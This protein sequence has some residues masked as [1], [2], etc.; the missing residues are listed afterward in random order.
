MQHNCVLTWFL[1]TTDT[2]LTHCNIRKMNQP[3][4]STV[5]RF[6]LNETYWISVFK[7]WPEPGPAD[8]ADNYCTYIIVGF[9]Q[10]KQNNNI[11]CALQESINE[12]FVIM[13]CHHVS[14]VSCNWQC[15]KLSNHLYDNRLRLVLVVNSLHPLQLCWNPPNPK[16]WPK[17]LLEPDLPEMAECWT[18]SSN[19]IHP[20]LNATNQVCH[21]ASCW[22][23]YCH[24][25]CYHY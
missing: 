6:H 9:L 12:Y 15:I 8:L 7:I 5:R 2:L 10:F 20:Y 24:L 1:V 14:W 4:S 18:W 16:I 13:Q 3:Q 21:C 11:K 25:W 17:S 22:R 23:R 19:P